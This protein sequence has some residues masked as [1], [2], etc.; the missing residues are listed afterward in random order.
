MIWYVL[1]TRNELNVTDLGPGLFSSLYLYDRFDIIFR[2]LMPSVRRAGF[3][4]HRPRSVQL[5]Q[6]VHPAVLIAIIREADTSVKPLR[7]RVAQRVLHSHNEFPLLR[8]PWLI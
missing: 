2:K 1:A 7:P 4:R 8:P 5:S 6:L 3:M